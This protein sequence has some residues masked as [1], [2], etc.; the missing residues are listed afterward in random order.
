MEN[1]R[2][3]H[4]EPKTDI[5]DAKL[6]V[7]NHKADLIEPSYVPSQE[8]RQRRALTRGRKNRLDEGTTFEKL[9]GRLSESRHGDST[10]R[11]GRTDR[12][13]TTMTLRKVV[14]R[15]RIL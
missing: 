2:D 4:H 7:D 15:S 14:G 11:Q 6:L 13:K 8:I 9:I 10:P 3:W 12:P 5:D 1:E